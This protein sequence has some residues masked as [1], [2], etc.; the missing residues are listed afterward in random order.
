MKTYAKGFGIRD[1]S[2]ES[3][4][5]VGDAPL[6][7]LRASEARVFIQEHLKDDFPGRYTVIVIEVIGPDIHELEG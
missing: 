6:W 3:L 1:H 4:L 2:D 5:L 7:F